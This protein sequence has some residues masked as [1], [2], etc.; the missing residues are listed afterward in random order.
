MITAS[1]GHT[2]DFA[3]LV[4][5]TYSSELRDGQPCT[6]HAVFCRDCADMAASTG[7]ADFQIS[8]EWIADPTPDV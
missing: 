6:V 4:N 1:C 3:G 2:V 5:V 8:R 7:W